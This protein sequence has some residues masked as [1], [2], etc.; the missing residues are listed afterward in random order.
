MTLSFF[1]V[2]L[3]LNLGMA[4]KLIA[5]ELLDFKLWGKVKTFLILIM[6][7]TFSVELM[8]AC[9][10]YFPFSKIMNK[11]DAI[12][13]ALF[14][15]VSAFCNAGITLF[16][17]NLIPF[18]NQPLVMLTMSSVIIA[19]GLG[20]LVWYDFFNGV[21]KFFN[22]LR[23]TPSRISLTL[24]TKLV[25]ST[26]AIL[27]LGG[28]TI[29]WFTERAHNFVGMGFFQKIVDSFFVSASARSAGFEIIN[30]SNGSH[31][32]LFVLILLMF[33]G[34]SPSST[35]SGIKTTTFCLA[36]ASVVA[37]VRNRESVELFGRTIPA[38]QIYKVMSIVAIAASWIFIA[39]F[40]LLLTEQGFTFMQL[41][42]ETVSAFG[43]CGYSTKITPTISAFG[44]VILMVTMLIGR[45]GSLT[46]VLALTKRKEKVIYR[47]PEERVVIG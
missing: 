45:I 42:F 35:G 37:I 2:S 28:A 12:F 29:V 8:G 41:L 14:H 47:Y 24:H 46:L 32:T 17:N 18:N 21:R 9:I 3:V 23:G 16:E 38:D 27:L 34:A 22:S 4:T 15:S 26:T 31:A 44:K 36:F 33:I 6:G 30:F 20:F 1:L 39:T 19:G 43:T 7:L 40:G 10:L 25:L 13:Y 11:S 5:G